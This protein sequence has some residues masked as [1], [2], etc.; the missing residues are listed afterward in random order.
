MKYSNELKVG[1]AIVFAVIVFVVGVRYF[2]DIPIFGGTYELQTRFDN[3]GGLAQ[4]S[5]V[6]VNGVSVGRVED[7]RL[8]PSPDSV[9][10]WFTIDNRIEIPRGSTTHIAGL[11][12]LGTVQMEIDLGPLTNPAIPPGGFVRSREMGGLG[13]LMDRAPHF[14]DRADSVLVGVEA[15]IGGT[16]ALVESPQSNLNRSLQA[17]ENS[18][19]A[20]EILLRTERVR[21][22]RVLE[23]VDTLA[24]NLNTFTTENG[25]SLSAAISQL[26]QVMNRLDRNLASLETTTATLDA[27]L[28]KVD[29]GEGTLG[30]LINDPALYTDLQGAVANLNRI[31]ADFE[32]NP[33]KYLK[34][35]KL[36]DVF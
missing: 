29:R 6:R 24:T 18:A 3:V 19:A 33:K 15:I 26:T 17:I 12:V 10:V 16:R 27:I 28:L 4:G 34:D 35:L 2:E 25:D 23:S 1:A 5:I 20:L 30:M 11:S 13:E 22:A 7:V 32:Q 9:S 8:G 14:V 36:V 31:L 21:V